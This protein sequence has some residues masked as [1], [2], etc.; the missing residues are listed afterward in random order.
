MKNVKKLILFLFL[1]TTI[2]NL[3][4]ISEF[5]YHPL[6]ILS[7]ATVP[8]TYPLK[9]SAILIGWCWNSCLY[10]YSPFINK[11]TLE[12]RLSEIKETSDLGKAALESVQSEM[13][14]KIV[15]QE[16]IIKQLCGKLEETEESNARIKENLNQANIHQENVFKLLNKQKDAMQLGAELFRKTTDTN[17]SAIQAAL[18]TVHDN[19]RNFN[20]NLTNVTNTTSRH[21]D[22]NKQQ[23]RTLNFKMITINQDILSHIKQITEDSQSINTLKNQSII[24][25]KNLEGTDTQNQVVDDKISQLTITLNLLAD[26]TIKQTQELKIRRMAIDSPFIAGIIA[27]CHPTS[28][29]ENPLVRKTI[30]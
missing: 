28:R 18:T 13:N 2:T 25:I 8:I 9:K 1:S 22:K 5:F 29:L 12:E 19:Q 15:E 26:K 10:H 24:D 11:E 20:E 30:Y 21:K 17:F 27:G 23:M 3:W 7:Y 4:C 16:D 6:Q 14:R